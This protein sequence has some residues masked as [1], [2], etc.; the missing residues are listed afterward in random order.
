M[1]EQLL[2]YTINKIEMVSIKKLCWE[3][4]PSED[5]YYDRPL[6]RIV[7]STIYGRIFNKNF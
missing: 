6:K 3:Q 5:V 1:F 2:N 4:W 7:I